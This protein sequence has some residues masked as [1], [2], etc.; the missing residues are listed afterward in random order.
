MRSALLILEFLILGNFLFGQNFNRPVPSGVYPYEYDATDSL[1]DFYI[2]VNSFHR[3]PASQPAEYDLHRGIIL[4]P[5]G[6]IAWYQESPSGIAAMNNLH[7]IPELKR[8]GETLIYGGNQI[9]YVMLDTLLQ[10]VDSIAPIGNNP[11]SHEYCTMPNGNQYIITQRDSIFDLSPYTINGSPGNANTTVRCNGIQVFDSNNNLIYDWNSCDHVHPSEA[12]GFNY[13]VNDFDYFHMNSV[14]ETED[15]NMIASGRHINAVVK[16]DRSSGD[17]IWRLGGANS[18]F[19]F[20]GDQGFSAQ[21]DARDIGNNRISIY[22]NGNLANP[23]KTRG[24]VYELDTVNWT[25][26][27]VEEFDPNV[28]S[29]SMGGHRQI[30]D[31][32]V[33][34]YGNIMR[35]YP[36]IH[37]YDSN[38]DVAATY[39]F[40]DS[41]QSY[42][43]N[44]FYLDFTLPRPTIYCFDSLGQT[45]IK[46]E[47]AYSSYEWSTGETTQAILPILGETY[48]VYVPYGVGR[49]GSFPLTYDGNCYL[50]VSELEHN[51]PT[52]IRTVDLLGRTV[53]ARKTGSLYIDQ[54]SN[55]QTRLYYYTG[56]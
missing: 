20:I 6:Y 14:H 11:D 2:C 35:P 55:G 43:A 24:V 53:N 54:L 32:G 49:I 17:V 22:D 48:Q 45:Y 47:N 42:R 12:Y 56:N 31:Y 16:I 41:V 34:G 36:S 30:G 4:D 37:I 7:Y 19:M 1:I 3:E 46:A 21:H 25:A 52:V 23:Q 5:D 9:Q 8:F 29:R 26:T 18:D 10:F 40:S 39:Y 44:P 50:S 38:F 15:G 13:N 27:L 28:Y 33:M 51:E